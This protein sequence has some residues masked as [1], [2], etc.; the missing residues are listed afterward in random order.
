M[1]D[2]L[3][4]ALLN[5]VDNVLNR[6]NDIASASKDNYVAWCSPGIPFQ[7]EDL[8]FA[9]KGLKGGDADETRILVRTAAEFSQLA[10]SIPSSNVIGGTFEQSG[11]TVWDIYSDVLR[12]SKIPDNDL[13]EEEKA[14]VER[15]RS[16]L[17]TTQKVKDIIT[18][19][20]K[21]I[22]TDSPMVVAYTEMMAAYENA[23]LMYNNKRLSALNSEDSQAVQDFALNASL[24][25]NQVKL[26]MNNWIGKGYKEDFEKIGA[27]IRHVSQRNMTLLKAE[28]Q[29]R[30]EKSKMTDP[31][32]GIDFF[33]TN[34]YPANFISS[35]KGWA[36]FMFKYQSKETYLKEKNQ[37]TSAET[38][39]KWGLWK[40]GAD[41]KH[42]KNNINNS[43]ESE[44]FVM[45]FKITQVPLG[46]GWFSPD[47]ILNNS[48]DWD[49]SIHKLLSNG[50]I[51]PTGRMIAYPTTAVF[52]K[53]VEITGSKVKDVFTEVKQSLD[54][55][56]TAGYGPI[57]LSARHKRDSKDSNTSFNEK[58]NTLKVKGMQLLAFKCFALPK[59]PD[60]TLENLV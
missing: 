21:E 42:S 19:E 37:S 45:K 52:I 3:L 33:F 30:F 48:W 24:Y 15:L 6:G 54:A 2:N 46:R 43:F 38:K 9:V 17:V 12:F 57:S 35:D 60:C 4:K 53:D 5:K 55:G 25:R 13:S 16:M 51:P 50:V 22:T 49:Q 47:F 32:S 36:D 56:G 39:I 20:E 28:L 14:K 23:V 58:T 1:E 18:D 41:A 31:T 59:T 44:D 7:E 11:N 26:A 40:A 29:D 34:F 27:Y 10:N 8:Q